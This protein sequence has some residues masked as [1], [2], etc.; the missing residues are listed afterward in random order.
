MQLYERIFRQTVEGPTVSKLQ[1]LG[2]Q[3]EG[4]V[5]LMKKAKKSKRKFIKV[6]LFLPSDK[7]KLAKEVWLYD[8]DYDKKTSTIIQEIQKIF[9]FYLK[10]NMSE[11]TLE[12]RS[13]YIQ[14]NTQTAISVSSTKRKCPKGLLWLE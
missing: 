1:V 7:I 13:D 5:L 11:F 12:K 2:T 14:V 6:V 10:I 9:P 8:S 3:T 4:E